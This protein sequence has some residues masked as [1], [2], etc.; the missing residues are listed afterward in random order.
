MKYLLLVFVLIV[1]LIGFISI[2]GLN[3]NSNENNEKSGSQ[4]IEIVMFHNGTGPMCI[5]ALDFFEKEN[6]EITEYLTTDSNFTDKLSEY[7]QNFDSSE[8][9]STS[10]SYYPMIFVGG[11][12]FSGFDNEIGDEILEILNS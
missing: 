1:A 12:A 4:D 7:K 2:F 3:Q 10:F 11:R 8:G 5:E 9:V 6:I